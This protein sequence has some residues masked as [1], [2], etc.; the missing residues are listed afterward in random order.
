ML[1]GPK[2]TPP[3]HIQTHGIRKLYAKC[4]SPCVNPNQTSNYCNKRVRACMDLSVYLW[5]C[6]DMTTIDFDQNDSVKLILT[7]SELKMK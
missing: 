4:V 3:P 2:P 6:G 7:I 1:Q 5:L